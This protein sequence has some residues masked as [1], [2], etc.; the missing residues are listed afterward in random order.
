[1]LLQVVVVPKPFTGGG[2]GY[3]D[4]DCYY[5]DDNDDNTFPAAA[6][7]AAAA[8]A[9]AAADASAATVAALHTASVNHI[10]DVLK[11]NSSLPTALLPLHS[12]DGSAE[13]SLLHAH[14]PLLHEEG[15]VGADSLRGCSEGALDDPRR[16]V[17]YGAVGGCWL[18]VVGCGLGVG[19]C[20][21]ELL[22]WFLLR[23]H[24]LP[25]RPLL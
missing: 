15:G 10:T 21:L 5:D 12:P 1:M 19:G 8:A 23:L 14:M 6:S 18:W 2:A 4:Y 11:H 16:C 22:M 25:H 17:K 13:T 9:A 24:S 3:F 7:A 20:G